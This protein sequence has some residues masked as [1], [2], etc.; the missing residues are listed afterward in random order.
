[1]RSL[2]KKLT[3]ALLQT[4][5]AIFLWMM[6]DMRD[7]IN[8]WSHLISYITRL[9]QLDP[10]DISRDLSSAAEGHFLCI[11]ECV[12]AILPSADPKSHTM[13]QLL[14]M[15]LCF[16]LRGINPHPSRA[17]TIWIMSGGHG[18][19]ELVCLY[20]LFVDLLFDI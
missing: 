5:A 19:T 3:H 17:V 12:C 4:V 20:F 18:W 7:T 14:L 1:M 2:L 8:M 11:C 15:C 6:S 16:L 9:L 10:A 13:L